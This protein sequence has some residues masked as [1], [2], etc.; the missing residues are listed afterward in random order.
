V[1]FTLS[2][3]AGLLIYLWVF[4]ELSYEKFHPDY[5][6]IY[7]VLTLS[8]QGDKIVKSALCYAPVA[9]T[10]KMDYPQIENA[11]YI[12]YSSEDSPLQLESGGDK[13]EAR[14]SWTSDDFFQIF[15]GFKFMEGSPE[16]AFDKPENIVIYEKLARK[17]F[18]KNQALGKKLISSKYSNEVYT[19]SGVIK[20]PVQSHLDLGFIVSSKN[21]RYSSFLNEFMG[22]HDV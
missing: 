20:I 17:I 15:S 22:I 16:S 6:Q 10:M 21:S 11:A 14:M 8:K 1:G 12:G 18:G 5:Q 3:V 9:E 7:R 2:I 19:V 4:N 13:I